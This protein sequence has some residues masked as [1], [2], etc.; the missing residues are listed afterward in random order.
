M[1]AQRSQDRLDV[2]PI[3]L[4]VSLARP[5]L[6]QV[7]GGAEDGLGHVGQVLLDV[8]QVH[9]LDRAGKHSSARFQ[10][11]A[12]PSPSTT[13]R[14]AWSNPRRRASRSTRCANGERPAAVSGLAALSM[15][16]E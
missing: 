12:A 16:A 11:Q 3:Q 8:K 10:I 6:G 2:A 4:I 13:R 7:A 14:R 15:A 5:S 1:E 9:D